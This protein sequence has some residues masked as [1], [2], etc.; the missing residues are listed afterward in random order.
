MKSN[1]EYHFNDAIG[2]IQH[3]FSSSH[4]N[5]LIGFV[6]D[7]RNP[8]FYMLY[9]D[10]PVFD[11]TVIINMFHPDAPDTYRLYLFRD[12]DGFWWPYATLDCLTDV[13]SLLKS[14]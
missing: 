5:D 12:N 8:D 6:H 1:N 9:Q 14:I 2:G 7:N 11:S 10:V 3:G 13:K 4:L